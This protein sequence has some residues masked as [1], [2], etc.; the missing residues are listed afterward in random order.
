[1]SLLSNLTSHQ[2][3]HIHPDKLSHALCKNFWFAAVVTRARIDSVIY[4]AEALSGKHLV[5]ME[6]LF[7]A[8]SKKRSTARRVAFSEHD[9]WVFELARGSGLLYVLVADLKLCNQEWK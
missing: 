3:M 6:R 2:E 9:S 7:T 5:C 8:F 4:R 1:M